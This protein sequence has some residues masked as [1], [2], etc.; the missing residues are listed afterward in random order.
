MKPVPFQSRIQGMFTPEV[1]RMVAS[2]S[3]CAAVALLV[4][5]WKLHPP[6][7]SAQTLRQP[8]WSLAPLNDAA[9]QAR[10]RKLFE[11]E[12]TV[13]GYSSTL[14][15]TDDTPF[16]TASNTRV[17]RGIIALSRDLLREFTPGA[18]FSY[19]DTVQ[20]HGVG[21]FQVE[22]TMNGRFTKRAD[23]WFESRAQARKWGKRRHL[24]VRNVWGPAVAGET[25]TP[26]R[27]SGGGLP[28]LASFE[29][30]PSD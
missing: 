9:A 2:I 1:R 30:A 20:V 19:G 28:A 21:S 22:D 26:P 7:G 29:A 27:I 8:A 23:I 10:M 17:R 24:L 5:G 12:V 16:I 13:T 18:P 6:P 3:L 25:Q 4:A 15:Q 11:L 14:D